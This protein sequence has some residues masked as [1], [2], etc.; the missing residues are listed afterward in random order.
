MKKVLSVFALTLISLSYGIAQPAAAIA[1]KPK[2]VVG[3]MIDQMRWDFLHRYSDRY[4]NDGFKRMMREGFACENTL[5]PYTQT[6]TACGHSTVY[7]GTTPGLSGIYGN[8]W[9]DVQK[10]RQVYCT[11]DESVKI[12]GGG[13]KSAPMSPRNLKVTTVSD[14]PRMATNFRS[15]VVG[16]AIKDRGSILPAGHSANAA[17]WYDGQTGNWVSSTYYMEELP[18]WVKAFNARKVTDSLYA[19]DWNTLYPIQ[20]Y[21]QSDA[22]DKVYE[23]K[24]P[25]ATK[26]VFPHSLKSYVGRNF[27]VI[28]STPYGNTLT[29]EFAKQT[30]QSENM[31]EDQ[32]TD[33]LAVGLSSPDYIGH[34]YGPNSI[35]VEDTYL[36]LDQELAAFFSFLD[37]KFGKE[38]IV[39]LTADHGV[40]HVPGYAAEHKLP[41]GRVGTSSFAAFKNAE[42]KFNVKK[43]V[44]NVSNFQVY[45]NHKVIDSAKLDVNQVKE[46]LVKE[47]RKESFLHTAYDN[48]D[49]A[50]APLPSEIREKYLKGYHPKL[51][52]DIQMVGLSGFIGPGITGTTHGSWYNYDAHIPLVF[53]GWG[54]KQGKSYRETYM[55]DVAPTIAAL[56]NIQ[57]PSASVGHVISEVIK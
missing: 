54:I 35:E 6:I 2:I 52:G 27:G 53:M 18:S 45:L 29:L 16:V 22:D 49:I 24:M 46:Y 13:A 10:G 41:G 20:T 40:A 47:L 43:L 15:K 39:F 1:S 26:P 5:I 51:S 19:L 50:N 44:A 21:V 30:I 56:L 38:Y 57:M 4:G 42:A 14:E 31:G 7:T 55:T 9:Y 32:F 25:G 12:L 23:G 48:A 3:I 36:R 33:L 34:Q 17:Y 37:K 28:S 8:E 11:E